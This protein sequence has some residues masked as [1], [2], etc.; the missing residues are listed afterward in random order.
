M[1]CKECKDQVFD[2]I[3]RE[4]VD[5]E[6]VHEILEQ[7]PDCRQLFDEIKTGLASAGH[8]PVEEPPAAADAAI[9]GAAARR[10]RGG[11]PSRHWLQAPPWAMAAIALLAIGIG[12]WAVPSSQEVEHR[13]EVPAELV[14]ARLEP[15]AGTEASAARDEPA[16]RGAPE[17]KSAAAERPAQRAPVRRGKAKRETE[18]APRA[19]E[20]TRQ[21]AP[22]ALGLEAANDEM[23]GPASAA[24]ASAPPAVAAAAPALSEECRTRIARIEARQLDAGIQEVEP[25]EALALGRCYQVAGYEQQAR[26]WLERAAADPKTR[27]RARR[28]LRALATH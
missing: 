6:G 1:N 26:A 22:A 18:S 21:G 14:Q 20:S 28:A 9:L 7:C 13:D 10:L 16:I 27:A 4:V 2:L 5:P 24:A 19:G 8:L 23:A 25:E 17:E 11:A 12:I 15:A 3:D